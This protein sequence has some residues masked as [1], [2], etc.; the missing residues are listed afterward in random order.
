MYV[1]SNANRKQ[2]DQR[3]IMN[4]L[5]TFKK[6]DDGSSI[7]VHFF[8]PS[9]RSLIALQGPKS[10]E[11]LQSIT[12][13]T[14][15][16]LYF[17]NTTTAIVD[18]VQDCRV[19]RCGYTGEDGFEL[20][21]PSTRVNKVAKTILRNSNVKLAGLGAR[22]S[23][24]L[25]AGLCLYGNDMTEQISPIEAGL[26]WLVAKARRESRGFPGADIIVDQ[27]KNGC[28]RKRV[29]F[30]LESG[31]PARHNTLVFNDD[32]D[33][34]ISIDEFVSFFT[35]YCSFFNAKIVKYLAFTH[36]F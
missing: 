16:D 5:E 13:V 14:L 31:P 17:M 25:E 36:F 19:T 12:N 8:T 28:P 32:G 35:I 23:L 15:K 26:T 20:S 27:I 18:D 2:E 29:G 3:L 11:V 6:V 1:V 24:R 10:P 21:I 34:Q 30:V 9:E 7:K 4:A 22:D 33:K